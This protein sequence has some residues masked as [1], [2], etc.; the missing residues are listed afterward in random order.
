MRRGEGICDTAWTMRRKKQNKGEARW[1]KIIPKT[2]LFS[3]SARTASA[4]KH[5]QTSAGEL[6]MGHYS[7]S[8]AKRHVKRNSLHTSAGVVAILIPWSRAPRREA[9][10][11]SFA[12]AR[13]LSQSIAP[14]EPSADR[15]PACSLTEERCGWGGD[16]VGKTRLSVRVQE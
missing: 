8:M 10:G 15:W 12:V 16:R 13:R 2:G 4:V 6:V 5:T 9:G 1:R 7:Y 11:R 14:H 3:L